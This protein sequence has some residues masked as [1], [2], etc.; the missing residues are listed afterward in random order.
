MVETA[1]LCQKVSKF[2]GNQAAVSDLTLALP[3]GEFWALLGP[4]GCGKTTSLRLIAGLETPDS[5][6][7]VLHQ[8]V[9]ADSTHWIPPHQ[10]QV[11][12]VFQNY[13]LFPHM[14]VAHNIGYG[15]SGTWRSKQ[16]RIREVL[17]LVD[18]AGLE[19]RYPH[20]LSGG[21]QQR[22]ALAR[23]LAPSP[24]LLLLD[25]PFSNLDTNLRVQVREEVR[26]IVKATGI[27]TIL[28][29][30]D[31]TEAFSLADQVSIMLAGHIQQTAMPADIYH[32][33]VSIEVARFVGEAIFLPAKAEGTWAEC[34]LL[35]RVELQ[36]PLS[37]PVQILFR[38]EQVKIVACAPSAG[39]GVIS[40]ITYLGHETLLT[41]SLPDGT[42]LLTRGGYDSVFQRGQAVQIEVTDR[43]LAFPQA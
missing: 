22:V 8:Q 7:I 31:Q 13:A 39:Q 42:L 11:G 19:K 40:R 43:L 32:R 25:E 9:V 1:L 34:G 30:H 3:A 38:P 41:L 6:Q 15:L 21:Q 29:T 12:L 2:Y 33:P 20:E 23:A 37:G 10:R 18:L 24:R 27:A 16:A 26:R 14:D 36:T 35:G 5:G 17:A 4:S 28:V